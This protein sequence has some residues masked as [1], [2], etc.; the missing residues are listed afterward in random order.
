MIAD[1][2]C[3]FCFKFIV[4]HNSAA[5]AANWLN[6]VRG[7]SGA[8]EEHFR[9]CTLHDRNFYQSCEVL[10]FKNSR[11]CNALYNFLQPQIIGRSWGGE[12][13]ASDTGPADK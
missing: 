5:L 11:F 6:N 10:K 9:S 7:G 3:H 8:S 12:S 13:Q 4:S 2:C 1:I